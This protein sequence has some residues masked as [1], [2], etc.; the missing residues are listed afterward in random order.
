MKYVIGVDLGG[1]YIKNAVLDRDGNILLKSKIETGEDASPEII[2][3]HIVE[4]I[5]NC[6]AKLQI[7]KEDIMGVGVGSPGVMDSREGI[8]YFSPNLPLWRNVPLKSMIRAKTGLPTVI[9]NDANAAA[10]GEHWKGAGQGA[11]NMLLYTLGTG[12][13]GGVIIN[14]KLYA[15][16][17]GYGGELG[18]ITVDPN[19]YPCGCGNHGCLEALA[20][21]TSLLRRARQGIENGVDTSLTADL[22]NNNLSGLTITNAARNGDTFAIELLAETGRALGIAAASMINVFNPEIILYGGGLSGAGDLILLPLINEAKKRS[23]HK[24]FQGVQIKLASLGNDAGFMGAA[25]LLME[26]I[27]AL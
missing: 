22:E 12:I 7:K 21:V 19:G 14:H 27:G 13:G 1:T 5:D 9:N 23:L 2:V 8:V 24:P 20:S 26:S 16:T 3:E 4:D 6:I 15:G 11:A 18:H 25:A 10:F 17:E